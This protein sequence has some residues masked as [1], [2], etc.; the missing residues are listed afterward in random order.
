M[1]S[2]KT[3]IK[4]HALFRPSGLMVPLSFMA[5]ISLSGYAVSEEPHEK[6]LSSVDA[7][8]QN[9]F[10]DDADDHVDSANSDAEVVLSETTT[11]SETSSQSSEGQKAGS[12][13]AHRFGDGTTQHLP[14]EYFQ[15]SIQYGSGIYRRYLPHKRDTNE[16]TGEIIQ[17]FY[18]NAAMLKDSP[19][20]EFSKPEGLQFLGIVATK[21]L[22]KGLMLEHDACTRKPTASEVDQKYWSESGDPGETIAWG[23]TLKEAEEQ[24]RTCGLSLRLTSTPKGKK[25]VSLKGQLCRYP[26][27]DREFNSEKDDGECIDLTEAA[28]RSGKIMMLSD[29]HDRTRMITSLRNVAAHRA[30]SGILSWLP[31]QKETPPTDLGTVGEMFGLYLS[32][33]NHVAKI[34]YGWALDADYVLS[35]A[36]AT[37]QETLQEPVNLEDEDK[38]KNFI[39]SQ[40]DEG[41]SF[42]QTIEKKPDLVGKMNF[43][44]TGIHS[45]SS[46]LKMDL[47]IFDEIDESDR[48]TRPV[49]FSFV[50]ETDKSLKFSDRHSSEVLELTDKSRM[51][52][53]VKTAYSIQETRNE[54]I[55]CQEKLYG[56][57]KIRIKLEQAESKLEDLQAERQRLEDE[58]EK[59]EEMTTSRLKNLKEKMSLD[60][61]SESVKLERIHQEN[62]RLLQEKHQRELSEKDRAASDN[63]KEFQNTHELER[64]EWATARKEENRKRIEAEENGRQLEIQLDSIKK[65]N[66][67]LEKENQRLTENAMDFDRRMRAVVEAANGNIEELDSFILGKHQYDISGFGSKVE[68]PKVP[69]RLTLWVEAQKDGQSKVKSKE[70]PLKAGLEA[71]YHRAE[72]RPDGEL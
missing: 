18:V 54:L 52:A 19:G 70:V 51:D 17:E 14:T 65:S 2:E 26:G 37:Y 58:R 4:N 48:P 12:A 67:A 42:Y 20:L 72:K 24:K 66:E 27:F 35:V 7:V 6:D 30:A 46:I 50:V 64:L 53:F 28:Q 44:G 57:D 41:L 60:A 31:G 32:S 34:G 38:T 43:V 36:D 71:G 5:L 40:S 56:C 25:R 55:V 69:N 23:Q 39:D 45:T 33:L 47:D 16:P 9:G 15:N 13:L 22:L 63:L 1:F 29:L 21:K 3:N 61:S 8:V 11:D 10:V 62:E 68:K 49:E 59:Y